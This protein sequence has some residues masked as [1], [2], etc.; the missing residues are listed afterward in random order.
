[1]RSVPRSGAAYQ[2][3][4]GDVIARFDGHIAQ[5]LGDGLLVYFGFPFAHEDDAR[6]AALAAL[7]MLEAVRGLQLDARVESHHARI[8]RARWYSY[9]IGH[10]RRCGNRH[11]TRTSCIGFSAEHCS[12][13]LQSIAEPNG[14]LISGETERLLNGWFDVESLGTQELKGV[15]KAVAVYRVVSEAK[16]NGRFELDDAKRLSPLVGRDEELALLTRRLTLSG[17]GNG[18]IVLLSGE[19]GVGQV[20]PRA[21]HTRACGRGWIHVR[22]WPVSIGGIKA[23]RCFLLRDLLEGM[24]GFGR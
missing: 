5:Y 4:C 2:R 20:A 12:H 16:R 1:M 15:S 22:G 9:R 18:F 13:G 8:G 19:A 7:G 11:D 14:V 10:C 24:I 17:E 3:A 6:R 21:G 23:V